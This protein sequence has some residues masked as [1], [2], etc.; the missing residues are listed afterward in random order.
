MVAAGSASLAALKD[1][2]YDVRTQSTMTHQETNDELTNSSSPPLPVIGIVHSVRRELMMSLACSLIFSARLVMYQLMS[3]ALLLCA[4]INVAA[5][6][7][8]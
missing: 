4:A 2:P 1:R 8:S 3:S 7:V 5:A 6:K